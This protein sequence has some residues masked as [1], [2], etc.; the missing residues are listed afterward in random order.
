MNLRQVSSFLAVVEEGSFTRAARRMLITQ[1]S[2]S[3]QIRALESELGGELIERLPR[4]VRLT[5]AGRAF[6]PDAQ[7]AV[8]ASER[9]A[10]AARLA[11]GLEAGELEVATLLSMAVGILPQ[12]ITRWHDRHPEIGVRVQ[13]YTHPNLLEHDVRA[14]VGDIAFGPTPLAW[15]DEGPVVQLGWEEMVVVL[16]SDDPLAGRRKIPLA[17]LRDRSWILFKEG[18]GLME[19]VDS[20]C[21]Q[22]GFQPRAAIRT[23]Q[24]A[25]A[26]RL[27]SE[28]LG[29]VM[30]PDNVAPPDLASASLDPPVVREI[31]AYSRSEWS[32][33]SSAFLEALRAVGWKRRPRGP[34]I[35]VERGRAYTATGSADRAARV[36]A[37]SARA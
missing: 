24:V 12:A 16:P 2:L 36:K 21:D 25:A 13:E 5:P 3:Q 34:A 19:A 22:A 10:T 37:A 14:G 8:R 28:G 4:G 33:L 7:A 18:H 30:V 20:A 29:I 35:I 1:P 9:A 15:E 31:S 11:L 27:A 17:A 26:V 6:L 23:T 32:P